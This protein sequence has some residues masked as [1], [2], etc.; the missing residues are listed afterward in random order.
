MISNQVLQET[1]NGIKGITE[2]DL[3]VMDLS[4]RPVVQTMEAIGDVE[5]EVRSFF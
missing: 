4:G 5:K 1:I 2:V 3:C